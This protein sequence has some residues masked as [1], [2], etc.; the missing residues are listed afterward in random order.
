MHVEGSYMYAD[1]GPWLKTMMQLHIFELFI[2]FILVFVYIYNFNEHK[3]F[4]NIF[5]TTPF[6]SPQPHY[7]KFLDPHM[8][9][10]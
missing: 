6:L 4:S 9:H 10:E 5:T 1:P 7:E 8:N 3:K 2:C